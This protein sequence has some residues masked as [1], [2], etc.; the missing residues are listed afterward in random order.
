M[1]HYYFLFK[2]HWLGVGMATAANGRWTREADTSW[3]T[4]KGVG[5]QPRETG[6]MPFS[7]VL[8]TVNLKVLPLK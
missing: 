8:T 1:F 3:P 5:S 7:C 2:I 4:G 6:L